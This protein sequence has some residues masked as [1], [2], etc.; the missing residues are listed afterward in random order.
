[1]NNLENPKIEQPKPTILALPEVKKFIEFREIK[2]EDLLLLEALAQTSFDLIIEFHNFFNLLHDRSL[3]Q[4]ERQLE[5]IRDDQEERRQF[6][7]LLA[8]FIQKYD[9]TVASNLIRVLE[10]V[11]SPTN[12]L[13]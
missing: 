10:K 2:D 1:M 11:T 9:W 8:D 3:T 7:S 13:I 12:Q 6:L 5:N 4:L